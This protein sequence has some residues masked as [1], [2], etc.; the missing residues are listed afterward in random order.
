M[1]ARHRAPSIASLACSRYAVRP[2][3]PMRCARPAS[4]ASRRSAVDERVRVARRNE[5]R[6]LAVAEQLA[7]GGGVRRHNGRAAGKCL[8][9][10][11]RDHAA[12]LGRRSEDPEC[13]ACVVQLVRQALVVDPRAALD[14]CRR[15]LHQRLELAA[16]HDAKAKLGCA[17][18]GLEDRLQAVE[19]Y[20]LADEQRSE[21]LRCPPPRREDAV[22]LRRRSRPSR[23]ARRARGR[24]RRSPLCPRRRDRRH[25]MLR[26]RS[27][28]VRAQP[29][30]A[31]RSGHGPPRACLRARRVG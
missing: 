3:A 29:A 25:E 5:K 26:G 31:A 18:R 22:P 6:A 19:R 8:K 1:S 30:T 2:P 28:A 13:A 7:R 12:R 20:Q 27:P 15:V 21:L 23:A 4:L 11:V 14:I 10:L 24:T 17:S 16:P 9:D